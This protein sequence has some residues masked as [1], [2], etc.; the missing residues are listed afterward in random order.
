VSPSFPT[1]SVS[2]LVPA[3]T[4]R[5]SRRDLHVSDED[6][7]TIVDKLAILEAIATYSYTWDDND[8]DGF[9]GIF[10]RDAM[11]T[12]YNAADAEWITYDSQDAIRAYT[13]ARIPIK[14]KEGI[15][16]RHYQLGTVFLELTTDSARTK[17]MN[18]VTRRFPK[19]PAPR[20]VNSGH[21]EDVWRRTPDGWKIA[22]RTEH[23]DMR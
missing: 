19:D 6:L 18:L 12:F 20:V 7:K 15:R 23:S 3:P 11:W 1:G 17:T 13:A 4:E 8:V 2:I 5:A 9:A 14:I 21:W 16:S 10:T 22:Q